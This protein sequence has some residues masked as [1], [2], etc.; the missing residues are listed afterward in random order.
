M[1][2]VCHTSHTRH[3]THVTLHAN[4]VT[5]TRLVGRPVRGGQAAARALGG[6]SGAHCSTAA[7]LRRALLS[8]LMSAAA[9]SVCTRVVDCT[10]FPIPCNGCR[11]CNGDA[12]PAAPAAGAVIA[13]VSAVE[14]AQAL[15]LVRVEPCSELRVHRHTLSAR[16][17][18]G[19]RWRRAR[20]LARRARRPRGPG[21]YVAA[22]GPRAEPLAALCRLDLHVL[23][24]SAVADHDGPADFLYGA[25]RT[26]GTC[27]ERPARSARRRRRPD[28]APPAAAYPAGLP[29]T[30]GARVLL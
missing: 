20:C 11:P 3:V 29:P 7:R 8:E 14:P 21:A 30:V 27:Q 1:F 13:V 10:V 6:E 5:R 25:R 9:S 15:E 16:P 26:P 18:N 23:G 12:A 22:A 17:Q 2:L 19:A 28:R 24:V 4:A